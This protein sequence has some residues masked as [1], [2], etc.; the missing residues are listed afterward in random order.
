MQVHVTRLAQWADIVVSSFGPPATHLI[1]SDMKVANP[2]LFWLADYRD[3]WSQNRSVGDSIELLEE[4]RRS[5][6]KSVGAHADLL[7]AVSKDMVE[8]LECL[9]SKRVIYNPNGFDVDEE[10]V[11]RRLA[12]P[13][14]VP[15]PP[16][17]IVYTGKIYEGFHDPKPVLDAL[18]FLLQSGKIADGMITLDIYGSQV[19]PIEALA[20][21]P[22]YASFIRFMGHVPRDRALDAQRCAWLLLLLES[23]SAEA[24]GI[25]TGKLYE[26]L[27]AGR[28]IICVGSRQDFEIGQILRTTGTGMVVD[29]KDYSNIPDLLM[30]TL[31]GGGLMAIYSPKT[32][33]ILK[34]SRRRL[35]YSLFR[36][37]IEHWRRQGN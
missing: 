18:V 5:E 32:D 35:A 16:L 13:L 27:T 21:D 14:D 12:N 11:R 2:G 29:P 15:E 1:G 22:R 6:L 31:K 3:L 36:E 24:R 34:Y 25:L 7:S 33:E 10:E 26:Y 37:L 9:M 19:E 20:K 30:N 8:K 17:R 4:I 28:P 23:S